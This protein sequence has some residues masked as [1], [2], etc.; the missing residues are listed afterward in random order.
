MI[1]TEYTA[2]NGRDCV[3]SVPC[4]D[5]GTHQSSGHKEAII[6]L[7]PVSNPPI[8]RPDRVPSTEYHRIPNTT[9]TPYSVKCKPSILIH[10]QG[11]Q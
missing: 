6:R 4:D 3:S 8:A 2:Q 10:H 1:C 9:R 5:K 7:I 11:G